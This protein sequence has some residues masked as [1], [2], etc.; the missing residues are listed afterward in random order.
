MYHTLRKEGQVD[1]LRSA[2]L[3]QQGGLTGPRRFAHSKKWSIDEAV[4]GKQREKVAKEPETVRERLMKVKREER[5]HMQR[6]LDHYREQKR[7][8]EEGRRNHV[9]AQRRGETHS[10]RAPTLMDYQ[11]TN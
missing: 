6:A 7:Q 8:I 2:L 1:D 9:L 3:G 4:E 10:K 11:T 5:A